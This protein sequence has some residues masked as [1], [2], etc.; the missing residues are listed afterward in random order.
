MAKDGAKKGIPSNKR[1]RVSSFDVSGWNGLTLDFVA[2]K[3][4]FLCCVILSLL[5]EGESSRVLGA[6]ATRVLLSFFP[7]FEISHLSHCLS[8]SLE[9]TRSP[10]DEYLLNTD[11]WKCLWPATLVPDNISQH[12]AVPWIDTIQEGVEHGK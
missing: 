2:R 5:T 10:D 6:C 8:R 11:G 7:A 3:V 1:P 12:F 9:S 4:L